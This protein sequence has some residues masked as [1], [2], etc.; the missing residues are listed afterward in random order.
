[1]TTLNKRYVSL[2]VHG[3]SVHVQYAP[4]DLPTKVVK[5]TRL[6][7]GTLIQSNYPSEIALHF[8]IPTPF[9]TEKRNTLA[10]IFDRFF[11]S[12]QI[13][14]VFE[15]ARLRVARVELYLTHQG[16]NL[17]LLEV[18]D[19]E[20]RLASTQVSALPT[21]DVNTDP[22]QEKS[23]GNIIYEINHE[24]IT[25]LGIKLTFGFSHWNLD[26]NHIHIVAA[27]AIFVS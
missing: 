19:G 26:E 6:A 23:G 14:K 17:G 24:V 20:R 16:A 11:K 8:S 10:A 13:E 18:M 4:P 27:K 22:Y 25:S 9:M 2:R 7:E 1:M 5:V 12:D 21:I 15:S 3:T